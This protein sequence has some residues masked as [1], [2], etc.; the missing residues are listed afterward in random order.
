MGDSDHA[1]L[2]ALWRKRLNDAL[3]RLD[4]ARRHYREIKQDFA[5]GEMTAPVEYY[6][7]QQA[8]RAEVAALAEYSRVLAVLND[9]TVH[10][11]IPNE[12][13]WQK[14]G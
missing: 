3:L 4:C 8:L 10:G 9:L 11:K 12:D 7:I 14:A 13:D 2:E 6:A 5:P 1:A